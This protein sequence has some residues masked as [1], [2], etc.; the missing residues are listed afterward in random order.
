MAA[1]HV[2]TKWCL[3]FGIRAQTC[4]QASYSEQNKN[5]TS[6]Q[7]YIPTKCGGAAKSWWAHKTYHFVWFFCLH[8]IFLYFFCKTSRFIATSSGGW[9]LGENFT[10][11]VL[12]ILLFGRRCFFSCLPL[13][14]SYSNAVAKKSKP[15]GMK[16]MVLVIHTVFSWHGSKIASI[17]R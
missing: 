11:D 15:R 17:R 13:I 3:F 16:K 9:P 6:G 14:V 2:L 4:Q 12:C 1:Q 10:G 7:I 8:P 5:Q